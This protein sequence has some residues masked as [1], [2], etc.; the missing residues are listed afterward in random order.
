MHNNDYISKFNS[1]M[2]S[3]KGKHFNE[4]FIGKR[5]FAQ[6]LSTTGGHQNTIIP[7]I[8][9]LFLH[10]YMDQTIVCIDNPPP[11]K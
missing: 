7:L 5:K 3:F 6:V 9:H 10:L 1:V 2:R 8:E 4:H 11:G